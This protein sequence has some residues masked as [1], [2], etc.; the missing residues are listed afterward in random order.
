[1]TLML[2]IAIALLGLSGIGAVAVRQAATVRANREGLTWDLNDVC[3]YLHNR[4]VVFDSGGD[5]F[6]TMPTVTISG[7]GSGHLYVTIEH[8]SNANEASREA[9]RPPSSRASGR[10]GTPEIVKAWGRFVIRG[11]D[12]A[13]YRQVAAQFR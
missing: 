5:R 6:A 13:F 9:S 2:L 10:W 4:G 1:M 3:D 11:N 12:S 7:Y 8:C